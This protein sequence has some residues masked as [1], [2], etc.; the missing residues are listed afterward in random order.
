MGEVAIESVECV[1][2]V[3]KDSA[4]L[5]GTGT[6]NSSAPGTTKN[7]PGFVYARNA[8]EVSVLVVLINLGGFMF[9]LI[10]PSCWPNPFQCEA[11]SEPKGP[12]PPLS[13]FST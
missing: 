7:C 5:P 1:W 4:A 8:R 9:R 6:Q 11:I 2:I 10:H 12:F 3:C 13:Y